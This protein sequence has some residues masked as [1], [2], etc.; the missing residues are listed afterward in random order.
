MVFDGLSDSS[1]KNHTASERL[2]KPIHRRGNALDDDRL[3]R[4]RHALEYRLQLGE[5]V[6][7]PLREDEIDDFFFSRGFAQNAGSRGRRDADAHAREFFRLERAH[8]RFDPLVS[9]APAVER[10]L[11]RAEREVQIVVDDDHPLRRLRILHEF[12]DCGP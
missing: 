7:F 1:V 5:L 12:R 4:V 6:R 3:E 2:I 10:D 11:D 9:A 8:D